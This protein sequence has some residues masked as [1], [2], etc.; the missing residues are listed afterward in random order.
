MQPVLT[1][2]RMAAAD[3]ATIDSGVPSFVLMERAGAACGRAAA[4]M[5]G[6]TYGFRVL[7]ACGKGNNGGDGFVVAEWL[8]RRGAH[9]TVALLAEPTELTGDALSAYGRATRVPGVRVF[10]GLEERRLFR[11]DLVL[12]ALL[13]TG[14]R[15]TL[16]GALARAADAI[17]RSGAPVLAVD[18]PSGVDGG[19]GA[20]LGPAVRADVTVTMGALKTGLLLFPG[21]GLT[22]RIEV[23]DIGIVPEALTTSLHLV[24]PED[25]ASLLPGRLPTAHK[26][27]VGK[28]LVVAGARGMAGAAVLAARGALRTGAGLVRMALPESAALQAGA[29]LQEALTTA[30]PEQDGR[31]GQGATQIA[32]EL[33]GQT[34]AVALGPGLGRGAPVS[35]F[36]R[37]F[38]AAVNQPVVLDADGIA[39]LGN[40]PEGLRDR[41]GP[42]VLTPHSGELGRLLGIEAAQV[43]ADRIGRAVQAAQRTGC[44]VLLKGYRTVVARPDGVVVLVGAG[45][46]VLATAGTGDVLTGVIAALMAGGVD[47]FDAAWAGACLHGAAGDAV[48]RRMGDRGALAGEVADQ[49][50]IIVKR[51]IE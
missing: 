29:Q 14:F 13:G 43:D 9:C 42:T 50:P 24:S 46:P 38:L 36:V 4:R 37:D 32:C 6:G 25:A 22:G 30:L 33:A 34:D 44:V 7:V 27:S 16:C 19:S 15:G 35:T 5:L 2:A 39:A 41:A 51:L 20:V 49:L 18:I 48:G 11:A 23:A 21:A 3:R 8:A 12:D 1:P 47:P 31:I 40:D 26:R 17:G 28:V 10:V 45:G